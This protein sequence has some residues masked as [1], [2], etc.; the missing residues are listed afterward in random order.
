MPI[1]PLQLLSGSEDGTIKVWDWVEGRLVRTISVNPQGKVNHFCLAEV[2]DKWWIFATVTLSSHNE[3]KS[4]YQVFRVALI[5]SKVPR[6]Q[7]R[8]TVGRFSRPPVAIF[9][10]PRSN[11]IVALAGS[12]AYTFRLPS[13]PFEEEDPD[14][15]KVT[16]VKFVSDQVFTCGSFAPDRSIGNSFQD[17]EWFA[18]GDEKGVIR[19][20]H[21]LGDAYRQLDG[22]T[23]PANAP[24]PSADRRL[25]TT[26]L[27]WHAHAVSA[28][29][30]TPTAS[31]LL[32]VG[33][34]S[35]LVQWHLASGKKEF[36]PRLGG[37]PIVTLS[38]KTA[39]RG[40]EEEWWMGLADG[41]TVRVGGAS[42]H[43]STVGHVLRIGEPSAKYCCL[44]NQLRSTSTVQSQC[45]LPF[46]YTS[47]FQVIGSPIVPSV[48]FAVHRSVNVIRNF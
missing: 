10:S 12:K 19:L 13:E 34:E 18:T 27:H 29:A 41:S 39:G 14:S 44:A 26:S 5:E 2:L 38:V 4:P 35:V 40:V 43:V 25:P 3:H 20:W 23:N 47:S 11:Y 30:F 15:W 36:I 28:L 17:A 37:S 31:Q 8:F 42:G 21:G 9:A 48:D 16:T 22:I 33:E 46:M 32:S 6:A 7:L 45:R 24:L 1:N